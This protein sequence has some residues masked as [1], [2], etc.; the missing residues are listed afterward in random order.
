MKV[1]PTLSVVLRNLFKNPATNPFPKSE[2][3][4]IPEGFR[5][6]LVYHVDKCIGC[7]LCMNVCPA[8][9]FEYVPEIKKVTLWL[10]RCVFCQQCVDV[11]PVNALE[12]V[13]YTHLTLPTN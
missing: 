4:P 5:G 12:T 2:P 6:K 8:G 11:C 3:V 9:V 7:K 1:P 13:S 10:G